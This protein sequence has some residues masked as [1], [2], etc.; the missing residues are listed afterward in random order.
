M[1]ITY[2]NVYWIGNIFHYIA[3]TLA[4]ENPNV[5]NCK[6]NS[7]GKKTIPSLKLE[8]KYWFLFWSIQKISHMYLWILLVCSGFLCHLCQLNPKSEIQGKNKSMYIL[9]KKHLKDNKLNPCN[10]QFH[11]FWSSDFRIIELKVG[12]NQSYLVQPYTKILKPS[13]IF[14]QEH[15][16]HQGKK[17]NPG[18]SF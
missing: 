13:E 9:N 3:L 6:L 2:L 12:R 11:P 15:L 10:I 8:K 16:R 18:S 14:T 7:I 17:W 4:L 1:G 5:F